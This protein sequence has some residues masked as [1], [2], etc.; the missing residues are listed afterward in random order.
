MKRFAATAMWAMS[1][2]TGAAED[3][4]FDALHAALSWND[5]RGTVRAQLSGTMDAELYR[6]A[7]PAPG[8]IEAGGSTLFAPRLTTFLDV[9]VGPKLYAF[10]QARVDRGFDPESEPLTARWE[11]YAV[12]FTPWTDGRFNLQ[13]GRFASVVGNW[14]QRHGSWENPFVL[15]PLP[16]EH[17][18]GL[19]DRAAAPSSSVL[20]SWA[21][22]A[23]PAPAGVPADD[24]YLRLP[25]IWGPSYAHGVALSGTV[26]HFG[27]AAEVKNAPLSSRPDTWTRTDF[28]WSQATV[29][30]RISYRPSLR[31][32]FGVSA[33]RGSYL[34][35]E[36]RPTL[37]PGRT[38]S[39]YRAVLLGQDASFAWHHVQVWAE[40][41]YAR[42]EVPEVGTPEVFAY[43]VEAKYK[44]TPQLFVAARW[45]E[46]RFGRI[47]DPALGRVRWGGDVWRFDVAPTYRISPYIQTKLQYSLQQ[48]RGGARDLEHLFAAQITVRF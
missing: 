37:A 48:E 38:L 31:W 5:S 43:Y 22:V 42:F 25:L 46:E 9:E 12:R 35:K 18:T 36:A 45:N 2:L 13:V 3:D 44:L 7:Q 41:F 4:V 14:I 28:S 39:D 15:A 23:P 11:E 32:Q 47:D 1:A 40:V 19:W 16:Y 17:L 26:G 6:F 24:K 29:S 20:L 34:Q 30:G 21:H 27:Y 33:S 8:L 10:A